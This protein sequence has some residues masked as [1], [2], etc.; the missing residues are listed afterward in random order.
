MG[1]CAST[2]KPDEANHS[3]ISISEPG[4]L[5]FK[6]IHSAI[7]WNKPIGDITKLLTSEEAVNC[8]DPNNGNQPIHIAAQNGHSSICKIL[9]GKGCNLNAQNGK[10]NTG[11]HMA[12]GYDYYECAKIIMDAGGD[13]MIMNEAEIP[14]FRGLDGD[15]SIGIAAFMSA[16]TIDEVNE[17][18]AICDT[19]IEAIKAGKSNFVSAAL[20]A[21]KAVG[22]L[23]KDTH[24]ARLKELMAKTN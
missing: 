12:I 22:T 1:A 24:Q 23:W 9:V 2:A 20:K 4:A 6:P 10:G 3:S 8:V 16:E 21:K 18:F 13:I 17:A 15:K 14:S 11:I 5:D 19:E 7:R